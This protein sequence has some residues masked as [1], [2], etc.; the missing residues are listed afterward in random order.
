MSI[1]AAVKCTSVG[2]TS[3]VSGTTLL[4]YRVIRTMLI[5]VLRV[6]IVGHNN[7]NVLHLEMLKVG[8]SRAADWVG[9]KIP[10]CTNTQRAQI[11]N[12]NKYPIWPK[13]IE[14]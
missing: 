13:I 11:P 12:L 1:K 4:L 6:S 8:I 5:Y 14:Q 10:N 3:L 2:M 7:Q 9:Q